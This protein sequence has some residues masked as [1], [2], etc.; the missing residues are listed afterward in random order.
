MT[1]F[2]K[3]HSGPVSLE[4]DKYLA[5]APNLKRTTWA[6]HDSQY[7]RYLAYSDALKNTF[8]PRTIPGL[9]HCGIVILLRWSLRSVRDS[10]RSLVQRYVF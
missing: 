6:S 10:F 5:P 9:F 8:F 4:K 2:Y 3:I 7:T 1:F